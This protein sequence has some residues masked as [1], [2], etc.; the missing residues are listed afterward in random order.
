TMGASVCSASHSFGVV[1]PPGSDAQRS[2]PAPLSMGGPA[3]IHDEACAG[4][5]RGRRRGE[6]DDR[7]HDVLKLSEASAGNLGQATVLEGLVFK[8]WTGQWRFNKSGSNRV[9]A[10]TIGGELYAHGLGKSF[11]GMLRHAVDGAI[12]RPHMPHLRGHVDDDA[13]LA[14]VD[15]LARCRLGD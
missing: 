15:H 13:A 1:S 10:N 5:E 2:A 6:I 14:T 3:A 12:G 11:D 9:D 7:T 8:E 4:D